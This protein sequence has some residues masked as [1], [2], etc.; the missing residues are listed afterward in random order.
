M[1]TIRAQPDTVTVTVTEER[2]RVRKGS[3]KIEWN[4]N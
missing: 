4:E 3:G 1:Q 2:E